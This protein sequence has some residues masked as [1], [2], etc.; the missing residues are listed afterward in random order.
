[1]DSVKIHGPPRSSMEFCGF[2]CVRLHKKNSTESQDGGRRVMG[3]LRYGMGVLFPDF[4]KPY[5]AFQ[6]LP[7]GVHR[8]K[9]SKSHQAFRKRVKRFKHLSDRFGRKY[10]SKRIGRKHDGCVGGGL[11][12]RGGGDG[13][14]GDGREIENVNTRRKS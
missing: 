8:V 14:M 12:G 7:T 2:P 3:G 11:W 10:V 9:P 6:A 1:M 4:Q 5:Q 13:N